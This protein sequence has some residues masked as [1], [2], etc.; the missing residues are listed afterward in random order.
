MQDN[1]FD[2]QQFRDKVL[3]AM[4]EDM[5]DCFKMD[6]LKEIISEEVDRMGEEDA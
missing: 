5:P 1:M 6:K 3:E 2:L 4:S